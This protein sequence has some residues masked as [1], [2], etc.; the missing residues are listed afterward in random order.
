LLSP[1]WTSN[2]IFF[3][4]IHDWFVDLIALHDQPQRP[5]ISPR[6]IAQLSSLPPG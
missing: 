3:S 5:S 4:S 6:C 1:I 2:L